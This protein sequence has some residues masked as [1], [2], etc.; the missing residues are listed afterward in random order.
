MQ[1]LACQEGAASN[2]KESQTRL[3]VQSDAEI[4]ERRYCMGLIRIRVIQNR[5]GEIRRKDLICESS[6]GKQSW[7]R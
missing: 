6:V 2:E 3:N 7:V 4:I 5:Y 1:H